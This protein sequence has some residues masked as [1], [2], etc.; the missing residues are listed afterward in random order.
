MGVRE[1]VTSVMANAIRRLAPRKRQRVQRAHLN[2]TY[3]TT[4]CNPPPTPFW[5]PLEDSP[6]KAL[7]TREHLKPHTEGHQPISLHQARISPAN[8]STST[9]TRFPSNY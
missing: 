6:V 9:L 1:S 5:I 8:T 2:L 3:R 4:T 7:T